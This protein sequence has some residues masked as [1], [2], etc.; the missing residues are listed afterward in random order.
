MT[1][2]TMISYCLLKKY[3]QLISYFSL[4]RQIVQ[5]HFIYATSEKHK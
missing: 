2:P 4:I 5:C 3:K 1:L